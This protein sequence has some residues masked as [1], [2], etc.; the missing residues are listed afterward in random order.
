[1]KKF[2][3][4][5]IFFLFLSPAFAQP[6]NWYVSISTGV[7]LG[8]PKGSIK[9]AFEKSGFNHTSNS[10]FLGWE[11]TTSYPD[12]EMGMP[13]MVRAGRKIKETK[14]IFIM[15]GRSTAARVMGFKNQGYGSF[16]GLFSGSYG[17]MVTIDYKITQLAFGLEHTVKNSRLKLGYAAAVYQLRY[18]NRHGLNTGKKTALVPGAAFTSRLPLGKEKRKVGVE[19]VADIN[20]APRAKLAA[21]QI[22]FV[23]ND[24]NTKII[25]VMPTT[26]VNMVHGTAGVALTFRKR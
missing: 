9:R 16:F 12:V 19:L 15:A 26:K 8:G 13:L 17:Q 24:F 3:S 4:A 6:A 18:H 21:Q 14:S 7:G 5:A 25:T 2:L 20:L 1:M 10:S 23:D 11:S 22:S